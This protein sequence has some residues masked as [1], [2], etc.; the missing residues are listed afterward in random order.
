MASVLLDYVSIISAVRRDKTMIISASGF[1]NSGAS[2]VMDFM[3]GYDSLQSLVGIELQ[4][5]HAADGINDLK[6]QLTQ[7]RERV[8]CN[9][10]IKRFRRMMTYGSFG[11]GLQRVCDDTYQGLLDE[12]MNDLIKVSWLGASWLDPLDVTIYA[13]SKVGY[14]LQRIINRA[15]REISEKMQFPRFQERYYSSME[16]DEFDALTRDFF[17]KLLIAAGLDPNKDIL[18]DMLFSATNPK[19]GTEFVKDP[20]II[21]IR[22]DPRDMFVR[23]T[24]HQ[25]RSRHT[26]NRNV[27]DF[28]RYYQLLLER[29]IPWDKALTVQYE[30]LIYN[31][32]PTTQRIMDFIG[33]SER[34][35]SE[36]K[37]FNPDVSVKYTQLGRTYP[38]HEDEVRYIEEHLGKYLYE[39]QNYI[40]VKTQHESWTK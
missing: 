3:R 28:T 10:A 18:V 1:G 11:W 2:A 25:N 31:Y 23:A 13:K 6:Y 9:A 34:P 36:F 27:K 4:L 37:Y 7:N 15:L 33:F 35:K 32:Y 16:E 21:L 38:G 22:R 19:L 26:P 20:R 8:A 12:Y 17:E 14:Y 24:E 29:S 40:P 5:F 30:D 39:F